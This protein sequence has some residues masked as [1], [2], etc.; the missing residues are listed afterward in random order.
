MDNESELAP[1][2]VL[3]AIGR[4]RDRLT[5]LLRSNTRAQARRNIHAHYDLSNELY[6]LFL[7]PS[8]T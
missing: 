2:N 7:D 1:P 8:M 4:F 5:H 3:G 6:A